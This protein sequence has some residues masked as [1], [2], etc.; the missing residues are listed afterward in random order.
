MVAATTFRLLAGLFLCALALLSPVCRVLAS[1]DGIP[2][3]AGLYGR[4]IVE[5][6]IVGAKKTRHNVITRELKSKPGDPYV[7]ATAAGDVRR[8]DRLGIFADV[9]IYGEKA[10]NVGPSDEVILVVRVRETLR[11]LPVSSLSIS[12]ENGIS[13]GGGLKSVN[14]GGK[15]IYLSAVARFGEATTI[16]VILR[17][18][19]L[20]GNH[21]GYQLE[22]Y[23]RDRRNE[24]FGFDEIAD[25]GFFVLRSYIRERG[26]IGLRFSFQSIQSSEPGKTLAESNTDNVAAIAFF[27]G[28]DSLDLKSNPSTG[29]LNEIDIE[30]SGVFSTNSD[31]WRTNV[32]LRRY[33]RLGR[34]QTVAISSL[35][36]YTAGTVGEDIAA[37]QQFGLGG[38]N[39]VRGWDLGTQIGK[40][41]FINTIEYRFLVMKPRAFSFFGIT[42]SLGLQLSLFGDFGW[43]WEEKAEF[44]DSFIDGYGAGIR[45]LLPYV[46]VLRLDFGVGQPGGGVAVHLGSYEK[47]TKQ[48]DRV[49]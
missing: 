25:E 34:R 27:L 21:L 16:E 38:T 31:F 10:E 18:R 14:L 37:W 36:T 15:A 19:W 4:T 29:W 13:I 28:Y 8:L 22:Y 5:V 12:D 49:R 39:S 3:Q 20:M 46:G 2:P 1:D 45:F 26:R 11:Y 6:Q 44:S 40:N 42:A 48:R 7:E 17:D 30:K 32:D 33:F 24:L 35:T 43:A 23:H 9:Q 41:Q 47:Q